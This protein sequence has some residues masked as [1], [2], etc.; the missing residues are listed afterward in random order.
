MPTD[1]VLHIPLCLLTTKSYQYE[2][3]RN[4][5][6]GTYD[7]KSTAT[8]EMITDRSAKSFF[9]TALYCTLAVASKGLLCIL[10]Q[11]KSQRRVLHGVRS[12][13]SSTRMTLWY[14][15]I[16]QEHAERKDC[17]RYSYCCCCL[18]IRIINKR[19]RLLAC[20]SS[21]DTVHGARRYKTAAV[22]FGLF[23]LAPAAHVRMLNPY[24]DRV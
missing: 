5:K 15:L 14:G 24:G 19:L 6:Q 17:K 13:Y 2:A 22:D 9:F 8:Q 23:S 7:T 4:Q 10:A 18:H 16:P 3:R 20:S 1:V 21:Y 11:E 12:V